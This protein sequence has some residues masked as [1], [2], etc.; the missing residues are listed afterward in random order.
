MYVQGDVGGKD[1]NS[2]L[3]VVSSWTEG[4][5]HV[6][7]GVWGFSCRSLGLKVGGPV[8][9]SPS[10]TVPNTVSSKLVPGSVHKSFSLKGIEEHKTHLQQRIRCLHTSY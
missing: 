9:G 10:G 2:G 3:S 4:G 6:G 1:G 7:S 8:V 5:K